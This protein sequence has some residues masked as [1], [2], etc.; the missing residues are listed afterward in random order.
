MTIESEVEALEQASLIMSS[1][2]QMKGL[3]EYR[4]LVYEGSGKVDKIIGLL[5]SS[6]NPWVLMMA[7]GEITG[8]SPAD[9]EDAG[10]LDAQIDAWTHW[11][12]SND[13]PS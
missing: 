10:V 11:A 6:S 5:R 7:L 12:E 8:E 13:G 4:T 3:P 1:S 9:P 2:L